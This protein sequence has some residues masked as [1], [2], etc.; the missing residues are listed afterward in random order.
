MITRRSSKRS[1]LREIV[2]LQVMS[3]YEYVGQATRSQDG[4]DFKEKVLKISELKIKSKDNDKGSRSKITKNCHGHAFSDEGS[5]NSNINKSMARMDSMAIK[6]DAHYKEMKYRT[7]YNNYGGNHS[8][9]DC[10][11]NATPMSHEEEAK[12]MQTF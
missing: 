9:A 7:E 6:M 2:I 3:K 1:M 4:K 11:D 10:N 12:F 5:S 8:T